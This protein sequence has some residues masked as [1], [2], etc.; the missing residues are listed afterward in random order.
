MDVYSDQVAEAWIT[1]VVIRADGTV[2]DLGR[3]DSYR[4]PW[5]RTLLRKVA[6]WRP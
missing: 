5:W 3:L 4:R 6:W 2:E 1:A